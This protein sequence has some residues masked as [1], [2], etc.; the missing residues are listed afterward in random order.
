MVSIQLYA[1]DAAL[2]FVLGNFAREGMA[3]FFEAGEIPQVRKLAALPRFDGLNGAVV[4]FQKNAGAVGFL[5]EGQSQ[6]VLAQPG[7][8]LNEIVL[9]DPLELC[10]SGDFRVRQ[11]HLP[12]PAAA[13]GATSTFQKNRH[14]MKLTKREILKRNSKKQGAR[15]KP[16]RPCRIKAAVHSESARWSPE[17]IPATVDDFGKA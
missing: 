6:P 13:G 8:L 2:I 12:R 5:L 1:R 7:E 3:D 11:A 17:T 14:E 10:Q 15:L 4:A 9:A 16:C